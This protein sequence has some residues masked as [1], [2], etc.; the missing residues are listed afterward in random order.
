VAARRVLVVDDEVLVAYD[1]ADTVEAL[2]HTPVGP[3]C[4]CAEAHAIIDEHAC[5][6]A[7]LDI[8]IGGELVWPVARRLKAM[9]CA[10]A[11]VTANAHRPELDAEFPSAPVVDKPARERDV[12][13]ALGAMRVASV[14][15]EAVV[16]AAAKSP[17]VT[18]RSSS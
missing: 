14:G 4:S 18:S 15:S 12:A 3:A 8:D 16:H 2:G 6:M 7:L 9:G 11:F 10:V 17:V 5:D 13:E 1:L